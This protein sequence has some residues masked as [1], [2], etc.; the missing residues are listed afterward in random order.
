VEQGVRNDGAD[1]R[2]KGR[3]YERRGRRNM[4]KETKGGD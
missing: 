1:T 2:K 3:T 4:R